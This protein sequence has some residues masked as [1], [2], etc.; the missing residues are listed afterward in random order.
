MPRTMT[1]D[2]ARAA[3]RATIDRSGLS[4]SKWARQVANV[5]DRSVRHW[6]K[7]SRPIPKRIV[8]QLKAEAGQ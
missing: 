8:N 3:L 4:A 5:T 2:D 7:G 1:N 6:L